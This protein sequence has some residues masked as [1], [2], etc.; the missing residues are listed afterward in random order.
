MPTEK[1]VLRKRGSTPHVIEP[2]II[3]PLHGSKTER[4]QQL[5]AK[6]YG[7]TK[8]PLGET[9]MATTGNAD[10]VFGE[11]NPDAHVLIVGEAPGE[12]EE[13]TNIPF[14][15]PT[16]ELLNQFL[17]MTSDDPKIQ[18][19]YD[20]YK[21]SKHT[22]KVVSQFH[23][24][25]TEWRHK[26]FFFTNAVSCRPVENA[27]PNFEMLKSCWGRLWNLIYTVDPLL[28]VCCGNSALSAVLQK[29]TVKISAERGKIFDVVHRGKVGFVSYPVM[30]VFPPSHL[31]RKADWKVKGGDFEKTKDDWKRIVRVL[32]FLRNKHFGTPI[33][34]RKFEKEAMIL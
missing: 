17:A 10:I 14:V 31:L 32:D 19:W 30:P 11:G 15:G 9:R 27:T 13:E 12:R 5:Y 22:A 24:N 29:A 18:E 2:S 16:G 33:P 4:L 26:E 7:C 1:P 3:D 23:H 21:A 28:I 8:C 34:D 25:I 20:W 6:W